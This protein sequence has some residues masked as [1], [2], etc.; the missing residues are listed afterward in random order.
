MR[1]KRRNFINIILLL[2]RVTQIPGFSNDF[3][4]NVDICLCAIMYINKLNKYVYTRRH[5][6][7]TY[8]VSFIPVIHVPNNEKFVCREIFTFETVF[9]FSAEKSLSECRLLVAVTIFKRYIS[10]ILFSILQ[11]ISLLCK[12]I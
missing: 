11:Y 1:I 8:V 7:Y 12:C 9:C 10:C 2:G 6:S 5:K 4:L 3:Y